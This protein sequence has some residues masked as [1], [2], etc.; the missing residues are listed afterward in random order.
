MNKNK[1]ISIKKAI[2]AVQFQPAS[3][4][5]KLKTRHLKNTATSHS[6]IHHTI[7]LSFAAPSTIEC[8]SVL[9]GNV[10]QHQIIKSLP[11]VS[12]AMLGMWPLSV[13]MLLWPKTHDDLVPVIPEVVLAQSCRRRHLCDGTR[14]TGQTE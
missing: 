7:S 6:H 5:E 11:C 4:H 14:N 13:I 8:S 3:E 2:Q 12:V 9:Q 1:L 10:R